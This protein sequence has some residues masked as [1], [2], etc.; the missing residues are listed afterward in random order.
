MTDS[1]L[2]DGREFITHGPL[3]I[4]WIKERWD[5]MD[6]HQQQYTDRKDSPERNQADKRNF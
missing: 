3:L 1:V 2:A 6:K 5:L 4:S